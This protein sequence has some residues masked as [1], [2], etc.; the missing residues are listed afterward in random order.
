M[1]TT[2]SCSQTRYIHHTLIQ[3][4]SVFPPTT[5]QYLPGG[6][7][8]NLDLDWSWQHRN[9][10]QDA[11]ASPAQVQFPGG[12][13]PSVC[14]MKPTCSSEMSRGKPL[15]QSASLC[16][17]S[18]LVRLREHPGVAIATAYLQQRSKLLL[19]RSTRPV[20]RQPHRKHQRPIPGISPRCGGRAEG[21]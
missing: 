12:T 16:N 21:R 11:K 15:G 5:I 7:Q 14:A 17:N 2:R 18:L 8:R 1:L 3:V 20:Q 6:S 9:R 13:Q 4:K 19:W 10:Q